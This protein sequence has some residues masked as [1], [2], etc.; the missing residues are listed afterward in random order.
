MT[1]HPK[2][3][4]VLFEAFAG[5]PAVPR[6]V[7]LSRQG[8]VDIA[9]AALSDAGLTVTATSET[10]PDPQIVQ[11]RRDVS[12]LAAVTLDILRGDINSLR[13]TGWASALNGVADRGRL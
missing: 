7:R 11:L 10:E 3:Q 6:H 1:H 9:L 5:T 12:T 2:A 13:A 4:S 8:V